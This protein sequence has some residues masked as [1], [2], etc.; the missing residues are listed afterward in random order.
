MS[1][2]RVHTYRNRFALQPHCD[3]R[4]WRQYR[5]FLDA[6]DAG[7]K[8]AVPGLCSRIRA[9]QRAAAVRAAYEAER[10]RLAK[11]KRQQGAALLAAAALL[12]FGG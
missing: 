6:E 5:S 1:Y 12:V 7:A 2:M 10:R 4:S 3:T 9:A 8:H 11:K